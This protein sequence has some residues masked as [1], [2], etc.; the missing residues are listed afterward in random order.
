[1]RGFTGIDEDRISG[2]RRRWKI[3]RES[4]EV[5]ELDARGAAPSAAWIGCVPMPNGMSANSVAAFSDGA[6]VATVLIMPGKT[7]EDAFAGRVTGAVFLWTAGLA[8]FCGGGRE[9]GGSG[10]PRPTRC[11]ETP[12]LSNTSHRLTP[13]P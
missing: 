4:I 3:G 2:L 1:M 5:F 11:Q 10:D 8:V 12:S 13:I 9:R 6:L 7:F